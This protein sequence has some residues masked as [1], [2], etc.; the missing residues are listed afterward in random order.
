MSQAI[1]KPMEEALI[2]MING[3]QFDED[4]VYIEKYQ[5][6]DLYIYDQDIIKN[7]IRACKFKDIGNVYDYP[8]QL[9]QPEMVNGFE[10]TANY[11]LFQRIALSKKMNAIMFYT[12]D[13]YSV[14]CTFL[15]DTDNLKKFSKKTKEILRYDTGN[16]I[17]RDTDFECGSGEYVEIADS[18]KEKTK[19]IETFKKKVIDENLVF[20]EDSAINKV[21]GDIITFFKDE[22]H[23]L[24]NKLQLAYKR[25][26]IL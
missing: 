5:R 22:T 20:D 10:L 15:I 13:E 26:V 21:M 16:N 8:E 11:D 12:I 2:K 6:V 4:D 25:G 19:W 17:F 14:C 7:I 24:Y 18:T 9:P 3:G 1:S 23:D